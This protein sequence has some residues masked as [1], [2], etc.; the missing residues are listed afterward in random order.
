[1]NEVNDSTPPGAASGVERWTDTEGRTWEVEVRAHSL[2]LRGAAGLVRLQGAELARDLMLFPLAQG[3]L[4]RLETFEVRA[5]FVLSQGDAARISRALGPAA[6]TPNSI[7]GSAEEASPASTQP[8]LFP[9]VSPLAIWALLCSALVFLPVVGMIPAAATVILLVLHRGR[10][11]RS[12]AWGHSRAVCTVACV[13][14]VS[15][16][17]VSA[18]GS[19]WLT[20]NLA[21]WRDS[22]SREPAESR[23]VPADGTPAARRTST[24]AAGAALPRSEMKLAQAEHASPVRRNWGLIALG[25]LVILLSLS[26]HEAAH[27]ITA[28]WLGDDF[29]RRLGRVR[30]NPAA[31]IDPFGTILLPL[32][33]FLTNGPLF[34]FAKPVPVRTEVLRNPR[35]DHMLVSLA[36]P[37]SN[38]LLAALS[39]ALLL[40]IGGC[41]GFLVPRSA[42]T[43]F[44]TMDFFDPVRATEFPGS[45]VFAGAA[46]FLRMSFSINLFLAFFNLIPLPPLDGSWVLGHLFPR[47]FGWLMDR[48]RPFGLVLFV[49]AVFSGVFKYLLLPALLMLV[50]GVLLLDWCTPF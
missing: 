43:G 9:R 41:L 34:G 10:V 39:L 32:I 6:Q 18:I 21:M 12:A 27:A 47:T 25:L 8:V 14:L 45:D 28:W 11:R 40:G 20:R 22:A 31:H 26:V 38:L 19:Y 46:T 35:R 4:L 49:V 5:A 37:G 42:I 23:R 2:T 15:G 36:G 29:A 50:P 24:P 48:L 17:G 33:L 44:S 7:Q 3:S 13:L 30:L 16:L 1:M